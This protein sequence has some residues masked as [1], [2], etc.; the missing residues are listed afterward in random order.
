MSAN[1]AF[2]AV[3]IVFFLVQVHA[4]TQPSGSASLLPQQLCHHLLHLS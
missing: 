3:E 4:A 2:S 1:N